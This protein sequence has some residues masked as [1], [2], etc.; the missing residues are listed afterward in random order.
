MSHEAATYG[1]DI[2]HSLRAEQAVIGSVLIDPSA[3]GRIDLRPTNFFS[4]PHRE[5]WAALEE[6][7]KSGVALD[8]VTLAEHLERSARLAAVGGLEY[9]GQI[10]QA[11]ISAAHVEHYARIVEDLAVQRGLIEAA[12][13]VLR[14]A[15]SRSFDLAEIGA[16]ARQRIEGALLRQRAAAQSAQWPPSR[17]ALVATVEEL[18]AAEL[19]PTCIVQDYIY[20]DV[21]Q[22]VAPGGTGKTTLLLH[23]AVCIALGRPVWG[24]PVVTPGWTLLLT[25]EDQRERLLARL[26]EIMAALGLDA[27]ERETVLGSVVILDVTGSTA[28]LLRVS[29][30][31]ILRTEMAEQIVAAYRDDRPRQ[32]VIDPVVS[33]GAS[34]GMVNDNE[35]ALVEVA[36]HLVRELGCCVRYVH[37]TG[38]A[39]AR[40]RETDQY[41]GRGGTALPDGSRMTVMLEGWDGSE[42]PPAGC[43]AATGASLIKLRRHKI[44]YAPPHLPTIWIRREGWSF[45]G[46]LEVARTEAEVLEAQIDQVERFL[47]S[48]L[49]AG[50]YHTVRSLEAQAKI[51]DM[52]RADLRIAIETLRAR[53]RITE[54]DLPLERRHGRRSRY[55]LP[56]EI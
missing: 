13:D 51:I 38:K 6:L 24:L 10:V 55:I 8:I 40:A 28:K 43:Y 11:T 54:K 1:P 46:Y 9:L 12:Q 49:A 45:A 36:R 42:M 19:T 47:A 33:F 35:Q 52:S 22:I 14:A 32:I 30:G 23:E 2:P 26:R 48:R 44:S 15:S 5:I 7:A 31:N 18:S 21:G 17:R 27:G 3:M 34:E 39:N 25:K 41:S 53:G 29:D 20:A 56:I 16:Y 50:E 4:P 37:H